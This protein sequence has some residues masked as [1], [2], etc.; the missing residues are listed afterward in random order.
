[1]VSG[2]RIWDLF[3]IL[4][5]R[6]TAYFALSSFFTEKRNKPVVGSGLFLFRR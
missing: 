2:Y 4:M 6:Y 5:S 1:M 3:I